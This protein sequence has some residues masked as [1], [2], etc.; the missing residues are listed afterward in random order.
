MAPGARSGSSPRSPGQFS[1]QVV[2][3]PKLSLVVP[4]YKVQGYLPEC[5]DSVLGQ[6]CTDFEIIAVDDCSPDGSG[7]IL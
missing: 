1:E 4:V 7:A 5:L 6:D 2:R 3:M